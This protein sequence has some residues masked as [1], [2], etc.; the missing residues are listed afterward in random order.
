M[1]KMRQWQ[2]TL[3]RMKAMQRH[4]DVGVEIGGNPAVENHQQ[5]SGGGVEG[6]RRNGG[7]QPQMGIGQQQRQRNGSGNEGRGGKEDGQNQQIGDRRQS[8]LLAETDTEYIK[9]NGGEER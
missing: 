1:L 7:S 4:R 3:N 2:G 8:R 6:H 9:V 5:Q